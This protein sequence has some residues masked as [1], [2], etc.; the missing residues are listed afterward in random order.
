MEYGLDDSDMKLMQQIFSQ[1]GNIEKV[2]LY[3]SRAKGTNKAF[4]DIDLTLVGDRLTDSNLM[5]V[6]SS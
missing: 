6:M 2:L 4:S 3:G 5:D 1:V